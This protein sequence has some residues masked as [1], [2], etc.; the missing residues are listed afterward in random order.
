[1]STEFVL[2][3]ERRK[4]M[5]EETASDQGWQERT[6]ERAKEPGPLMWVQIYCVHANVPLGEEFKEPHRGISTQAR[7]PEW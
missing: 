6:Q 1:V 4:S 3:E 7:W 2:G 5:E